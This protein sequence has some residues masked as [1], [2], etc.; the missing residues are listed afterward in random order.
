MEYRRVR[1][2][3]RWYE[4]AYPLTKTV[5]LYGPERIYGIYCDAS[6]YEASV[7]FLMKP[8]RRRGIVYTVAHEL[9]HHE[10]FSR[11]RPITERGV[12]RRARALVKRW[13]A[14]RRA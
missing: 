5:F 13:Q 11:D 7:I 3:V 8:R 2:F 4:R 14:E 10:Q 1:S 9:V 12:E 6:G